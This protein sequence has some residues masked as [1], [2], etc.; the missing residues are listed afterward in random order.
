MVLHIEKSDEYAAISLHWRGN[1]VG[2][3]QKDVFI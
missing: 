3:K 2:F 1:G